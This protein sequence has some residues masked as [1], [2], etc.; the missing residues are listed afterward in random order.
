MRIYFSPLRLVTRLFYR[1]RRFFRRWYRRHPR[2]RKIAWA[3]GA[4]LF[5]M[6]F[7]GLFLAAPIS[8][9]QN[10]LVV[11]EEGQSIREVAQELQDT[12]LI[13]SRTLFE[14]T[15]RLMGGANIA[16]QYSF[17]RRENVFTVGRRLASGDFRIKATRVRVM[18]GATAR[19]IATLLGEKLE[20][21]D[22]AKFLKLAEPREGF[23]FPDTYFIYPGATP[24]TVLTMLE[25]TFEEETSKPSVKAAIERFG[26]P[27]E[28][29]VIMA[30]LLEKEVPA[31]E[32]RRVIA[33]ILWKRIQKGMPL[34]V[35]AV[36]PYIIGKNSYQLTRADLAMDS[37]YNTYVNKGLPI[38]PIAN[39][40][41]DAMLAAVT[42]IQTEYLFYLSDR[43]GN[44]HYSATYEQHLAAKRKYIDS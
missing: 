11:V 12:G 1:I 14:V 20:D 23:L 7:Y 35:D 18:E 44:M 28:D 40:S 4:L 42:P 21:F 22:E 38:G 27:I 33:G 13:K 9:P 32:D 25:T 39:P 37:P 43:Y 5:F 3:G 31:T 26:K 19:D 36:F 17:Q 29:I 8:F 15:V 24:E 6:F 10:T 30:S 16:G 41:L 2:H 34:Q